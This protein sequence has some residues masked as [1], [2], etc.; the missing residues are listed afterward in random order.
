MKETEQA[1]FVEEYKVHSSVLL[2]GT[3]T[4]MTLATERHACESAGLG[5][6]SLPHTFRQSQTKQWQKLA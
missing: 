4:W 2:L 1:N 3:L 5:Q 6:L